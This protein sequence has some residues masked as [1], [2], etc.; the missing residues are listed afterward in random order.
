M[1]KLLLILSLGLGASFGGRAAAGSLEVVTN[2]E[3]V[4]VFAGAGRMV[5]VEFHNP[6]A[7]EFDGDLQINLVQTSAASAVKVWKSP[8][9]QLRVLPGQTVLESAPVDFPAVRAETRFVV[10]WV[11]GADD[12]LAGKTE[13][14]VYPTNLLAALKPL[15]GE[16]G[17]GV[18]DP[19]NVLKPLLKQ[20]KLRYVDLEEGGL[21]D[22]SGKLAIIGPFAA[23][24]QM[25]DGLA[26]QLRTLAGR[27]VSI[28]W[29]QPPPKRRAEPVP[30]F[31]SVPVN[32]NTVGVVQPELVADLPGNPQSQLNLV[33]FCEL[34]LQPVTV[35]NTSDIITTIP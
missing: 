35:L 24:S 15:A 32:T 20:L 6:G 29:L 27:G 14:L 18:L 21:D 13:G 1:K 2:A 31:Y 19:E 23:R 11:A 12:A 3:P 33:Y 17:T 4:R 28:V 34:A 30:S 25:H 16:D 8:W 7:A 9:K 5:P 22:F 26:Q 10:Q